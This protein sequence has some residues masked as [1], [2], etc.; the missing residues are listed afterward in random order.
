MGY[1]GSHPLQVLITWWVSWLHHCKL[2]QS[3]CLQ[4]RCWW[5]HPC[6]KHLSGISRSL[7][8]PW[9]S[10]SCGIFWPPPG[11]KELHYEFTFFSLKLFQPWSLSCEVI[12]PTWT[13]G[14]T[15]E[16]SRSCSWGMLLPRSLWGFPHPGTLLQPGR[17]WACGSICSTELT[18]ITAGRENQS[19][20][21]WAHLHSCGYPKPPLPRFQLGF[22]LCNP[23]ISH[24]V[25]YCSGAV[26]SAEVSRHHFSHYLLTWSSPSSFLWALQLPVTTGSVQGNGVWLLLFKSSAAQPVCSFTPAP[27]STAQ[28]P[29]EWLKSCTI[30]GV[31]SAVKLTN[32][33]N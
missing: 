28:S 16:V 31:N 7:S 19:T 29:C 12:L 25:I 18:H 2:F 24:C 32:S 4:D 3:P 8:S 1:A 14:V 6:C 20:L 27:N 26:F 23:F 21:P 9:E 11:T 5:T 30:S 22:I 17:S 15:A 33:W 10:R 13:L